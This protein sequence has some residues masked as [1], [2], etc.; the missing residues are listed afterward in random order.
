[1]QVIL[2]HKQIQQKIIRL[3]HQLLEECVHEKRVFVGGI[4]GNGSKLAQQLASI[5]RENS[6]MEV[7]FFEIQLNKDEPWKEPIQLSIPEQDLKKGFII[8]V[9]D[10]VNSGKTMQYALMKFLEQATKAIKT[11]ALVDRSHRRYPIKTDFV[12]LSLSTTLKNH[13]EVDLNDSDAKAYL[14]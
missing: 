8:L 12:G 2:E 13:V 3:G 11:V 6:K 1:M 7:V 9:D 10:V 4:V 5:L 14:R